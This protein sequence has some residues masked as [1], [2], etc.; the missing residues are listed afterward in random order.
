MRRLKWREVLSAK[1]VVG[2]YD[3]NNDNILSRNYEGD[4][5]PD[6]NLLTK[7]FVETAVGIENI[8]KVF[9]VDFIWRLSYLDHDNIVRYGIR[10]K[11]QID[12]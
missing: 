10:A 6:V 7:P 2:G 1:M 9:R 4:A 11:F 8:F 5:L 12:F 3:I